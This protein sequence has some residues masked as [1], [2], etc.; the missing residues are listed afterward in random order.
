MDLSTTYRL[1]SA[2]GAP[3]RVLVNAVSADVGGGGTHLT[4]QIRALAAVD[5]LDLTVHATGT[6]AEQLAR[7][8]TAV[9]VIR[10]SPGRLVRRLLWEQLVFP[11]RARGF[12]AVYVP[13]NFAIFMPMPPQV[14][15]V[16]NAWYFTDSVRAFRRRKC[17]RGMR[18]RVAVESAL[19]RLSI[20]RADAVVAVSQSMRRAI[21]GDMGKVANLHVVPSAAP[22]LPAAAGRRAS[23]PEGP[24]VLVVAHDDPHKDWDGLVAT[25]IHHTDL[26]RLVVV[27]GSTSD[28]FG[29]LRARLEAAQADG[30]VNFLGEIADRR[31]LGELYRGASCFVAHS[32][33]ESFGLTPAEALVYGVPVVATDIPAHR[34]VCGPAARYY[35]PGRVDALADALRAVQEHGPADATAAPVSSRTWDDNAEELARVLSH[36]VARAGKARR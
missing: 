14:L 21:E 9:H 28:R 1:A 13:G 26:P 12:D 11:L 10:R 4:S 22:P 35:E 5:G 31:R 27:G 36:V 16:Q 6:V 3:L 24:Y 18:A 2:D 25:F 34:E 7:E 17:S 29:R 8:C 32:Y 20:R 19:A 23:P 15:T 33:F 30:R